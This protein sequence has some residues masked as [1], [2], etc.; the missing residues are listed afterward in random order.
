MG[1]IKVGRILVAAAFVAVPCTMSA[2]LPRTQSVSG[3]EQPLGTFRGRVDKEVRLTLRGGQVSSNTLSGTELRSRYRLTSP[4]PQQEGTI[5]VAT[6][7]GRG[8][9]SVI[10]QPSASNGYTAIIRVFDRSGGADQY[11]FTTYFTPTMD[12]R[13]GRGRGGYGRGRGGMNLDNP[14]GLH[15]SGDVD[16]VVE[17]TWR[18]GA[19]QTRTLSGRPLRGVTVSNTGD[20]TQ[21]MNGSA[22]GQAQLTSRSGRGSVEIIQQPSAANRYTTRI[23]ITDPVAG[24]GR[25]D[26]NVVWR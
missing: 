8:D 5:R 25:Y 9:V 17:L 10:Q 2:Q 3:Q 22:V 13:V 4:L 23:R 16:G 6:E 24:Y 21:L 20:A 15:W 19:A 14:P 12:T 11:R 26:F 1:L 7:A 18:G